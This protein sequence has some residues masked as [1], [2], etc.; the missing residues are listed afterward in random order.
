M[1]APVHPEPV[2][3]LPP[4]D[5]VIIFRTV[6]SGVFGRVVRLGSVADKILKAH[7]LP[8]VGAQ[9]LGEAL[10]LAALLGSALPGKGNIA[11][12][13]RTNGL[14]QVLYAD[15]EAPGR[16]RAYARFDGG[17]LAALKQ[18]GQTP[19]AAQVL[20]D[21]HLAVTIDPGDMA[22]RYQGVI[23]L[24]HVPLAQAAATYFESRE[25]LPTFVRLAVA[26]HYAGAKGGLPAAMSWRGGGIMIQNP[27]PEA[28][29]GGDDPWSRVRM[30]TAT[31]EDHELLDP[32]LSAERLLLR[33]F[34]EEGVVIDG[35]VPL[36]TYCKCSRERVALVLASFGA[37]D[38]EDMRDETGKIAAKCEF[39]AA[40]YAFDLTEFQPSPDAVR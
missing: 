17:T 31:V 9:A 8:E 18:S 12:Q 32:A 35:V 33:L 38:L 16:L 1:A 23:A 6:R 26:Q 20:G 21:G 22:E 28:D 7:G 11:V 34:H 2:L 13:T 29:E 24:D 10:A 15:C 39:C 19:G 36:T 40:A 37:D 4:D 3:T 27:Q 30:L 25:A 5:A 14:V